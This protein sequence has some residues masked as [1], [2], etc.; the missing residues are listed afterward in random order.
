MGN[1]RHKAIGLEGV[2]GHRTGDALNT[3]LRP[4]EDGRHQPGGPLP[5]EWWYFEA[6]FDHGYSAVAIVWPMNY[7]KPWRRQ[8]TVQ[9]SIYTPEGETRKHYI[10]PPRRLFS[11]SLES[12]DVRVG[13]SFMRGAYPRYEV[14]MEAEGDRVDLVFESEVP[15]WKPK[16]GVNLIPFPR[17]ESM[18]WVVPVPRA[19]VAGTLTVDGRRVEVE[20]HGYH[21]HNFGD[22][23]I[24]HVIDNWHWGHI[25]SGGL[26]V[27]W[28]DITTS[29][30]LGYQH[31]LMFLLSR[32]GRLVY[33][34]PGIRLEYGDWK[35]DPSFL[36]P[37]PGLITVEFGEAGA[38]A[39]GGFSM[40]VRNVIETQDLLD[41]VGIPGFLK[42]LTH[43]LTKPYY[44][45]WLSSVTG[46]LEV[47]GESFE[48]GGETIHEQMLFRGRRP[49]EM[50]AGDNSGYHPYKSV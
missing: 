31:A 38:P 22:T 42:G 33:E 39:R 47:E 26:G 50:M 46:S 21:D 20:G 11:A 6:A 24:F 2:P 48:L 25:V 29:R 43:S 37:Y 13:D 8:C 49:R 45:R 5:Y 12:C 14:S 10:F 15:G 35:D 36:H 3:G 34:S 17:L 30:G 1:Q 40:R 32:S 27:T 16:T 44:F 9:L 19:R 4:V 23:P 7:S 41:I 28:A 18:G